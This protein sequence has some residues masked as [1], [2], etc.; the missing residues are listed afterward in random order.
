M[1]LR[2]GISQKCNLSSKSTKS[3]VPSPRHKFDNVSKELELIF[4]SK[5]K[6]YIGGFRLISWLGTI[7]I[8]VWIY[9][10]IQNPNP[11]KIPIQDE[12]AALGIGM[13]FLSFFFIHV[14][15]RKHFK[16][17]Y[18]DHSQNEFV[19]VRRTWMGRLEQLKFTSSEVKWQH[20]ED[21]HE[22]CLAKVQGRT[23][24]LLATDFKF[25]AW[26]NS[27]LGVGHEDPKTIG[28]P[29]RNLKSP[30]M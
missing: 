14:M 5:V 13:L 28:K 10:E 29:R 24:R 30:Y 2:T 25:P 12:L 6:D 17:I 18:Y 16:R 22:G 7:G 3:G 15:S 23:I 9:T 21:I 19:A 4:Q 1:A 20:S 8:S 11:D 26:Y 27:I